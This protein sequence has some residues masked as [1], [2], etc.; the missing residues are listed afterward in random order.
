[1]LYTVLNNYNEAG[2]SP[3]ACNYQCEHDT[4]NFPQEAKQ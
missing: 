4:N 3:G 1:M 2:T